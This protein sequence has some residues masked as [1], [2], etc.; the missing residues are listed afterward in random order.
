VEQE[1]DN[2][3]VYIAGIIVAAVVIIVMVKGSE[4][5]KYETARKAIAQEPAQSAYR[6][7]SKYNNSITAPSQK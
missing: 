1:K 3:W 5:D 7:T 4:H 6:D 2:F